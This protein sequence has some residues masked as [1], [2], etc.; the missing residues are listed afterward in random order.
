MHPTQKNKKGLHALSPVNWIRTKTMEKETLVRLS[1]A[2]ETLHTH[3]IYNL[4][5]MKGAYSLRSSDSA[6]AQVVVDEKVFAVGEAFVEAI[7]S[8]PALSEDVL[9]VVA[10]GILPVVAETLPEKSSW[11]PCIVVLHL[12]SWSARRM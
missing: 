12:D 5:L 8:V 2:V 10:L 11:I 1:A 9:L 6:E 4:T 3:I 7:P